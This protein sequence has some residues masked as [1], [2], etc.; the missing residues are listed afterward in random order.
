MVRNARVAFRVSSTTS[1]PQPPRMRYPS[2]RSKSFVCEESHDSILITLSGP[3]SFS[4]SRA[5][6]RYRTTSFRYSVCSSA[7]LLLV[8]W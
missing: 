7:S 3:A 6:V 2:T 4:S 8:A 1:L 5:C